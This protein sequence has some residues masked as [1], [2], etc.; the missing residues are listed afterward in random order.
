[1]LKR[2]FD[3]IVCSFLAVLLFVPMVVIAIVVKASSAGPVLFWSDR[4][5]RDNQLFSMP[6]FR[7][8]RIDAPLTATHLLEDPQS[9][10]TPVGRFLRR[11]SADEF[12]QI[13]TIIIGQMSLVGPRPALFNQDDLIA[14]RTEKGVHKLRPGLTGLAQIR[15]RDEI[16]IPDKVALDEKYLQERSVLLDTRIILETFLHIFQPKNVSH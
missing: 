8:M 16:S 15:G 7:T 5:G 13:Y 9:F 3:I 4:V 14:L 12:P 6:K 10:I 11:T 2:T 1:M